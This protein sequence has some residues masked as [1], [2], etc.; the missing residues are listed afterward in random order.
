[1]KEINENVK[2]W[3]QNLKE[4]RRTLDD[5]SAEAN[6]L[7]FNNFAGEK[8]NLEIDNLDSLE[9]L[10]KKLDKFI[11]KIEKDR[12]HARKAIRIFRSMEGEEERKISELFGEDSETTR[13]FKEIT[14]ERYEKVDYDQD[15]REIF[16][17]N[18]SD[19]VLY[20]SVEL[21]GS[22]GTVNQ[23]YLSIRMAL[24]KEVLE[25]SSFFVLDDA[26]LFSDNERV[27]KQREILNAFSDS[28]WQILYLT[29]DSDD[30]EDLC[31][32]T[33]NERIELEERL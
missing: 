6:K 16:V 31:D 23:L 30:A 15:E 11:E 33:G 29:S 18:E 22:K 4:H 27:D 2:K 12:D 1:M 20:P 5:F 8:L 24:A 10:I 26:L 3:E 9:A 7:D 25:S 21:S 14:D 17:K 32:L 19:E 28:G 13:I